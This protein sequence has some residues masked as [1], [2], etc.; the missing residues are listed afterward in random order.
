MPSPLVTHNISLLPYNT[1]GIDAPAASFV[2]VTDAAELAGLGNVSGARYILGGG[3]NILLT[4][5]VDGLVIRNSIKGIAHI[6]EDADHIWLRV[7]S[8]EVWHELVMYAINNG[9]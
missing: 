8:G 5:P 4:G 7:N 2:S 9:W 6:K 3:S 1:F